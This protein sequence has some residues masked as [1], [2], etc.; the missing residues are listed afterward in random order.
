[1]VI[2]KTITQHNR[3]EK[4]W[5]VAQTWSVTLCDLGTVLDL[6]VSADEVILDGTLFMLFCVVILHTAA[7]EGF[8]PSPAGG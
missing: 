3:L 7:I 2:T 5:T 8:F 1:M 4:S 6:Y